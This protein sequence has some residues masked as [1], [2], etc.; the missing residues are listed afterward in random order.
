MIITRA[1]FRITLGGGGTDLPSYYSQHAGY[2]FSMTIDKYMYVMLHKLPATERKSIIR[3]SQVEIVNAVDEIKHP[4]AREAL[5]MHGLNDYIE[6]TSMADMPAKTGLG[7]SGAYLVSLLMA[8]R[9]Y[10]RNLT[11]PQ[12][13]AEEACHIE[14]DVLK[15]PVGKQDQYMA[16]FGG[17]CALEID[18]DGRV[19]VDRA[20]VARDA[21]MELV[22]KARIYYTGFQRSASKVLVSQDRAA[23][24]PGNS[25]HNRVIES[26]HRIKEIGRE[27]RAAF[28]LGDIDSFGRLMDAHWTA[29]RALS[30][31]VSLSVLDEL[32]DEVKKRFGVLGGKI[33]G[34]G[35]GGFMMLYAPK[36]NR[37]LDEFM[38]SH[39]MP[40]V[41]Y[42][43]TLQGVK[44]VGDLTPA[45]DFAR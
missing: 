3:Y 43:P 21:V 23:R 40:C 14:I 36:Q 22:A 38:E 8:I 29:K 5:R 6:L 12:Q 37:E 16:A 45:D 42:S 30:R 28:D 10:K 17:F 18:R 7:S 15:E 34:A 33:I 26:L 41:S 24:T 11:S 39:N 2:I 31:D 1:P 27:I 20:Q 19:A 35:G 13:L 9:A 4:L 25:D 44:I 32:Y